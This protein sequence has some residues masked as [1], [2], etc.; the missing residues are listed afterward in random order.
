MKRKWRQYCGMLVSNPGSSKT[1]TRHIFVP[2]EKK[3][4]KIR[5]ETRQADTLKGNRIVVAVDSWP[6]HSR[7]PQGKGFTCSKR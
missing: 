6:R 4:P 5:I 1:T 7:Y 3:I 2:A